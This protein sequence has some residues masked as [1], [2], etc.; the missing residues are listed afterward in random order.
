MHIY[1]RCQTKR[2]VEI[3][4][5]RRKE[6]L[7]P[8]VCLF[9]SSTL[10]LSNANRLSRLLSYWAFVQWAFVQWAFVLVG[11]CP[12]L[13]PMWNN[14]GEKEF[15]ASLYVWVSTMMTGSFWTVSRGHILAI[16]NRHSSTMNFVKE[17][18]GGLIH[19]GLKR[20]HSSTSPEI[21]W[22]VPLF[23]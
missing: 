4:D 16:F 11:V 9:T 2:D 14:S 20:G 13:I 17:K 18:Q 12:T 22:L 6:I 23:H 15:R 8:T 21:N 1:E 10:S 3:S 19:T 7:H 5:L